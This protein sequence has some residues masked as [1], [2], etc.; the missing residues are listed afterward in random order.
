MRDT[1][2]SLPIG[3]KIPCID[4]CLV[5]VW[6]IDSYVIQSVHTVYCPWR[7]NKETT[8]STLTLF[9]LG[10]SY[11]Q[12]F[13]PHLRGSPAGLHGWGLTLAAYRREVSA[14]TPN[15]SSVEQSAEVMSGNQTAAMSQ[16]LTLV[17]ERLALNLTHPT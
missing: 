11:S 7:S 9:W 3:H 4:F 8:H 12:A 15:I 6:M 16:S 13:P 2:L 10:V 17:G 5:Q 14:I 1:L